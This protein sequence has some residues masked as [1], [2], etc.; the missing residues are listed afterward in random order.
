MLAYLVDEDFLSDE[1]TTGIS[2][3]G[4]SYTVE[5]EGDENKRKVTYVRSFEIQDKKA[6]VNQCQGPF[7]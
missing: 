6:G 5:T 1:G 4:K 7:K 3:E 2:R